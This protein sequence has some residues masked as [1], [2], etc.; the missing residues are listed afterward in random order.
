MLLYSITLTRRVSDN[1]ISDSR[2]TRR[3]FLKAMFWGGTGL[4]LG[5]MGFFNIKNGKNNKQFAFAHP[6]GGNGNGNSS[7]KLPMSE[8][9]RKSIGRELREDAAER[10]YGIEWPDHPNNGEEEDYPYIANYSKAL[11]HNELGEPDKDSYKIFLRAVE[12]GKFEDWEKVELGTFEEPYLRLF[13]P[14]AG[15]TFPLEGPDPYGLFMPP[16]PRIDSPEGAADIAENYWLAVTRDVY[17]GDYDSNKT[18]A[19]AAEDLSSF[20]GFSTISGFSKVTPENI[21]RAN[22][23]GVLMGPFVS[24][25]ALIGTP[26]PPLGLR[27]ED[28]W[29][30]E[31][32]ANKVDQRIITS[33]QPGVDYLTDFKDWLKVYNGHDP[34]RGEFCSQ[35]WDNTERFMRYG[36]DLANWVHYDD[37]PSQQFRIA[38]LI[39]L[40]Q[41]VPCMRVVPDPAAVLF[42][43]SAPFDPENP[44]QGSRT[45]EAFF[46]FG[47]FHPL[48]FHTEIA[49]F[50]LRAVWFQKYYVHRRFRPE[51]FGALIHNQKTGRADYPIHRD[52]LE[53]N[54][55]D[56]PQ[57]RNSFML[58]QAFPEGS[59]PHPS[60]GAGHA[61]VV[62][63]QAT[64]LKAF[65]DETFVLRNTVVPSRDGTKLEPYR[66]P[67]R[68]ELTVGG[69]LNKLAWNVAIG[70]NFAGVHYRTDATQ[71]ILLGE[72]VAIDFLKQRK[73]TWPE[74]GA[75][76]FTKF[77]GERVTINF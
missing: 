51:A 71:S 2:I 23:P 76:N 41:T 52:I 4:A 15:L 73:E 12:S 75:F 8:S 28:G 18:I 72:K 9:E 74:S 61:T 36:R 39:L 60:Y 29:V 37:V 25:F 5:G 65:F 70:R 53:S 27:P 50:A 24:Q 33:K 35:D 56:Q 22:F 40:H 54:V 3:D 10:T 34:R 13:N 45:Q 43:G 47:P 32:W 14:V 1:N 77:N 17:V 38:T 67:D 66:G 48:A 69:E 62:G 55:F 11:R 6:D 7:V 49:L 21:F 44:Y 59:P 58:P 31:G 16:A 64:V 26:I 19:Q 20:S 46:N 63:A 42:G 68:D 30:V 57:F